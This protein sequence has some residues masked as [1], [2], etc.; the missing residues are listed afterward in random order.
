[1][2]RIKKYLSSR[3]LQERDR[4]LLWLTSFGIQ[5]VVD[6]TPSTD[7]LRIIEHH[8]NGSWDIERTYDEV[9]AFY[10]AQHE[11][12][13]GHHHRHEEAD[14]VSARIVKYFLEGDFSLS[15][16]S[17]CNTHRA[18]FHNLYRYSGHLREAAFSK[19]EWVLGNVSVIYPRHEEVRG[20]LEYL[21]DEERH[22]EL[23]KMTERHQLRHI[24]EFIAKLFRI[25][26]FQ[27]ANSRTTFVYTMKYLLSLGYRFQNDTF[28]REAWYFRNAIIRACY[29]NMHQGVYPTTEY[30]EMFLGNLFLDEDNE[31]RNHRMVIRGE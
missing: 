15:L 29:A 6:L 19:K 18:M 7:L 21:F 10:H 8:I 1:M 4:C 3:N 24:C 17:F 23:S 27:Y 28:A 20:F 11:H 9:R 14:K 2:E 31:L 25:N 12:D 13:H 22:V 5:S 26:A 16:D 30:M